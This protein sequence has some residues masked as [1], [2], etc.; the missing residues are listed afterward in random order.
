MVQGV[1]NLG[2]W[3]LGTVEPRGLGFREYFFWLIIGYEVDKLT[4]VRLTCVAIVGLSQYYYY[5]Y[6]WLQMLLKGINPLFSLLEFF[7]LCC[8]ACM[9]SC[10][11]LFIG[12]LDIF[13]KIH[14]RMVVDMCFFCFF[15]FASYFLGLCECPSIYLSIHPSIHWSP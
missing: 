14:I 15:F 7:C 4:S 6:W 1:L 8:F 2:V 13:G 9:I 3:G 12:E 5:Y 11:C 10:S